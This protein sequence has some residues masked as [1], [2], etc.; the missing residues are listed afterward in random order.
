MSFG[1][2]LQDVCDGAEGAIACSLMGA[3]GIEVE[4]HRTDG[5]SDVDLKS[6]L[7]ECSGLLRSARD[8][9]LA[10]GAGELEELTLRTD[11][12][13]AVARVISPDYFMVVALRPGGNHGK[14]RYLLRI[15][16]PKLRAEL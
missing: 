2:Y 6:L 3:D 12:L 11:R 16:A 4:T 8:A 9:T 10:Q 7:V 14:A 15:V 13:V 1:Q 5:P